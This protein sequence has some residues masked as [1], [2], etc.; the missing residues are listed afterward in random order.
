MTASDIM[1]YCLNKQA[2]YED[3]P[4]GPTPICV[5]VGGRIFAQLYADTAYRLTLK[6]EP[7]LAQIL[8]AQYPH[9]VTRGYHC[10]ASQQ[11][12]WNTVQI[13]EM[14]D[15]TIREMIDHSYSRAVDSLTKKVKAELNL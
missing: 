15:E 4:F 11:P 9:V 12:Y 5:K 8:R 6:C 14:E 1:E 3:Y 2:A 10:P 7:V 13:D